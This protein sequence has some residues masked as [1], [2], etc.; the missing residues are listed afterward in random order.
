MAFWNS[1]YLS[2][3]WALAISETCVLYKLD[4]WLFIWRSSL[5]GVWQTV[6]S[7]FKRNYF[8][9]FSNIDDGTG[10]DML[11]SFFCPTAEALSCRLPKLT[12]SLLNTDDRASLCPLNTPSSHPL[13]STAGTLD[14]SWKVKFNWFWGEH[15]HCFREEHA[16]TGLPV[17]ENFC[18]LCTWVF[19][20]AHQVEFIE[21]KTN[22]LMF[23]RLTN[24]FF[25]LL[26]Y[27]DISLC[28]CK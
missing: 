2:V 12:H 24:V 28:L 6:Q 26:M 13:S 22:P 23:C 3:V 15:S 14:H 4:S 8:L 16:S 18:I 7:Y 11:C 10:L 19:E 1:P 9:L 20:K 27:A 17:K 21:L 25:F 5:S